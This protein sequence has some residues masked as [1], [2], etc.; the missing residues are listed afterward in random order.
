MS[1]SWDDQPEF[2]RRPQKR[3]R[4]DELSKSRLCRS[5]GKVKDFVFSHSDGRVRRFR[6]E[7]GFIWNFKVCGPCHRYNYTHKRRKRDEAARQRS[8]REECRVRAEI[9]KP[10][11]PGKEGL[12]Q[13][14]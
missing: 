11:V 13:D 10:E 4:R 2:T 3:T 5:C 1:P 14:G 12:N 6:D 7:D 8:Q 9:C